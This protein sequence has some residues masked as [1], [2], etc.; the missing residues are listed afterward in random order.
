[1]AEEPKK[2]KYN[3]KVRMFYGHIENPYSPNVIDIPKENRLIPAPFMSVSTQFNYA[4]ETIIGYS[5]TVN[6][7]GTITSLDLRPEG[8]FVGTEDYEY[9]FGQNGI[10]E[11]RNIGSVIDHIHKIKKILTQ[12]GGV[13][14][15]QDL[16]KKILLRATGGIL[17]D[18]SI[19]ESTWSDTASYTA[20]IEFN[21][22]EFLGS[23]V[24]FDPEDCNNIFIEDGTYPSGLAGNAGIINIE[25][26]KIK[27]FEDNW[28]INFDNDEMS[29]FVYADSGIRIEPSSEN[30]VGFNNISFGVQYTIN[31]VGKQFFVYDSTKYPRVLPAWQQAKNFVQYR[32]NKHVKGLISDILMGN[33]KID[34]QNISSSGCYPGNKSVNELFNPGTSGLAENGLLE[35][36][37]RE[38]YPFSVYNE[39]ISCEVSES[40]GSFSATYNA[41]I[42]GHNKDSL[43]STANS[44]HTFTK[45]INT[46]YANGNKIKNVSIEGNIEGLMPGGLINSPSGI[47]LPNYGSILIYNNQNKSKYEYALECLNKIYNSNNYYKGLSRDAGKRDLNPLFKELLGVVNYGSGLIGSQITPNFEYQVVDNEYP[48]HPTNFNITHNYHEGNITYN[49]SYSNNNCNRKYREVNIQTN[50]PA[51]V[52]AVFNRPGS[53][54]TEKTNYIGCPMIQKLGTKTAKTVNITINGLDLSTEGIYNIGNDYQTTSWSNLSIFDCECDGQYLPINLPVLGNGSVLTQKQYTHNPIDGS[55]TINLTYVVAGTG[56]VYNICSATNF[57]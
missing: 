2:N 38:N 3:A 41:V 23:N 37:D 53:T 34:G 25:K 6:L 16:N 28:S 50:E 24:N 8:D 4:D 30:D 40:E 10:A 33:P 47:E 13:L 51:D 49:V 12:N 43:F 22:V 26:Y 7:N 57:S 35:H 11:P 36:L 56:C 44:R 19:N 21:N 54:Q 5:Y 32:L 42:K 1:M 9:S 15:I 46:E 31:A 45:N 39:T 29:N 14:I 48:P 20:S 17:R 27:S 52:I 18:F 55:F